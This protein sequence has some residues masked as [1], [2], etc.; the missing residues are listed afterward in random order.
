MKKELLNEINNIRIKMGLKVVNEGSILI[1]EAGVISSFISKVLSKSVI[2]DAEKELIKNF[3][4]NRGA[5]T[6]TEKDSLSTFFKS[7]EG[8]KFVTELR[9]QIAKEK[10][11]AVRM[12]LDAWL[13]QTE[14]N[15]TK[16][17]G[18]K[19]TKTG[20]GSKNLMPDPNPLHIPNTT[21]ITQ[22]SI[23]D[24]IKT[25]MTN[26]RFK[27]YMVMLDNLN[28]EDKVKNLTVLAYSKVGNDPVAAIKY[29]AELS[30]QL[31]EEKYGWIKRAVYGAMKNPSKTISI[32]GKTIAAGIF[33]YVV[34]VAVLTLGAGALG[35]LAYAKS[36]L[37]KAPENKD[38]LTSEA[39]TFLKDNGYW[40]TGMTVTATNNL[41]EVEW[42]TKD[43]NSGTIKKQQDG[44]FK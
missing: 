12:R 41:G 29:T 25:N 30:K 4:F 40:S 16:P 24:I 33:W 27:E 1:T 20:Q 23:D 36:V 43:G 35:W 19:T 14:R 34:V 32:G 13:T 39:E 38:E 21:E 17:K 11:D 9:K 26:Q 18:T 22:S 44:T 10:D 37:P 3:F 28:L 5:L 42:T 7:V 6:K 15:L 31:N 8:K 2:K